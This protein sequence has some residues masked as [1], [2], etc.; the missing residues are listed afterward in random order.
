LVFAEA[1]DAL[2]AIQTAITQ[3]RESGDAFGLSASLALRG[4]RSLFRGD[5]RGVEVD[6]TTA[7]K[8]TGVPVV[9][10]FR[11]QSLA[12]LVTA[13]VE[14]D[15]LTEAE[16]LE[17][18]EVDVV[19]RN[20][21]A[22][23]L[24][25]LA[26]GRVRMAQRRPAEALTNFLA[27]GQTAIRCEFDG[28]SLLPGRSEAALAHLTLGDRDRARE[29]AAAEL[30]RARVFAAPRTL[31]VANRVLGSTTEGPAGEHHI[32]EAINTLATAGA[33]VDQAH[34]IY[35]L[36]ARL[37]RR[38]QRSESRELLRSALDLADRAG[39]ASL[40]ARAVT[41]LRLAGGRPRRDVMAGP[42]SLTASEQRIADL[43]AAGSTNRQIAKT[44]FVTVRTVE[45]HLTN[46]FHK[47][48]IASRDQLADALSR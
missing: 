47:L 9:G 32:R 42:Y 41:E 20:T 8:A 4:W 6:A 27:V 35:D 38:N 13:L 24:L 1:P 3:A 25:R 30:D 15:R 45:G 22:D 12:S 33:A 5:L 14:M 39:A 29:L 28:P 44:L 40:A 34:A 19:G 7:L 10:F 11:L 37:R 31:G 26:R 21:L 2:P 18:T 23:V 36:G 46:A 43:A 16:D 48:G 17:A